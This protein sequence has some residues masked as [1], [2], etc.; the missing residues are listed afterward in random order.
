MIVP[1]DLFKL[2][3]RNKNY[4]DNNRESSTSRNNGGVYS[5]E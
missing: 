4:D 1:I 2:K 3:E 5:W